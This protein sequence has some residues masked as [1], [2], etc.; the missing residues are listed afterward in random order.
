VLS[1]RIAAVGRGVGAGLVSLTGFGAGRDS[2]AGRV[3]AGFASGCGAAV[4]S[5]AGRVATAGR[6]EA[7]PGL[8]VA[9]GRV[10]FTFTGCEPCAG[11]ACLK[12]ATEAAGFDKAACTGV[13]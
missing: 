3:V 11:T 6:S 8:A 4:F 2:A 5:F 12:S 9:T 13:P 7:V 1:G 10:S